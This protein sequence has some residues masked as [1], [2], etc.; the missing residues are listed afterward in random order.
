MSD[1]HPWTLEHE[2][3]QFE[4]D[5]LEYIRRDLSATADASGSTRRHSASDLVRALMSVGF[6]GHVTEI[7]MKFVNQAFATYKADPGGNWRAKDASVYIFTSIAS[8]GSTAS[9]GVTSK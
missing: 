3:E 9:H 2:V 5:P 4:D 1:A 7:M 6:E 8:L